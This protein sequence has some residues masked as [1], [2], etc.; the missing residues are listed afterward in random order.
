MDDLKDFKYEFDYYTHYSVDSD[1]KYAD[2][3]TV[4]Y[5]F[6]T[7]FTKQ[8]INYFIIPKSLLKEILEDSL[9]VG[10]SLLYTNNEFILHLNKI[11]NSVIEYIKLILKCTLTLYKNFTVENNCIKWTIINEN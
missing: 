5:T 3:L 11:N 2:I 9:E 10:E 1:Y 8:D 4:G 7:Q 6:L